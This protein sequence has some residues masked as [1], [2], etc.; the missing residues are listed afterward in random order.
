MRE[1]PSLLTGAE[2]MGKATTAKDG[3]ELASNRSALQ[4]GV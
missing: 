3:R 1:G 2:V 4:S